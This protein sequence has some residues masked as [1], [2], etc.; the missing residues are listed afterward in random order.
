MFHKNEK[1]ERQA[2][3]TIVQGSASDLVKTAMVK[4]D[5]VLAAKKVT[6]CLVMQLHDEL[7][8]EI[9]KSDVVEVARIIRDGMEKCMEFA[10]EMKVKIRIGSNWGNLEK[11]E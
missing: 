6:A 3:N 10:V 1:A 8:Y 11:Y 7:I 9:D 4:I 5:K 2:I